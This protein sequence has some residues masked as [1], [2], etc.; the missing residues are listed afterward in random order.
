MLCGSETW[1]MTLCISRVLGRFHHRVVRRITGRQPRRGRYKVW[2]YILLENAMVEAVLQEMETYVSRLQ[3]MVPHFIET[4]SVYMSWGY[5][6]VMNY[7][8]VWI[9]IFLIKRIL[10]LDVVMHYAFPKWSREVQWF[11]SIL[12]LEIAHSTLKTVQYGKYML[13]S[14]LILKEVFVEIGEGSEIAPNL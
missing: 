4:K 5:L 1:V 3:N 7:Y 11:W 10:K 9:V 8:G 2:I 13:R 12:W 6:D 14:C